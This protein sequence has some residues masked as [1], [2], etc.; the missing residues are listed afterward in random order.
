MATKI[1]QEELDRKKKLI[2]D[3][4]VQIAAIARDIDFPSNHL[5]MVI[6][7]CEDGCT[8]WFNNSYWGED[9]ELPI[10]ESKESFNIDK[11]LK[12][13]GADVDCDKEANND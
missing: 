11:Y 4:M 13:M 5:S 2:W 3:H 12:N 8:A 9:S 1:T 6:F 10:N 7:N